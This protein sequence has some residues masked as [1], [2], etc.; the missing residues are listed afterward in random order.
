MTDTI[1][2]DHLL[3]Q[4]TDANL[5]IAELK[6]FIREHESQPARAVDMAM[7]R[8]ELKANLQRANL[9]MRR[10]AARASS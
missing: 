7:I 9:L 6:R 10:L 8:D 3:A 1:E 4:W 2:S 5:R